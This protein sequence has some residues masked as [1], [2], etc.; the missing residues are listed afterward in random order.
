MIAAIPYFAVPL[1]QFTLPVIGA[2]PLDPWATLVCIGFVVGLEVARAR[3]I[4]QGFDTRDVI[5]GAVFIVLSGFLWGHVLNV[6]MYYPERLATEGVVSL[7][8][9]W[10]GFASFGGFFGAVLGAGLFYRWIRPRDLW[11]YADVIAY[12]FPFGWFFGRLG[13]GVVHDHVGSLTAMPWGMDFDHAW[14]GSGDPAPW[15]NGIRHE[16]GLEE[17]AWMI[18][19]MVLFLWLGR[20]E[21]P[22][23][24]FIGWFTVLYAPMRFFLECFRNT[25]L[26]APDAR[27]FGYTPAQYGSV[28]ILVLGAAMLVSIRQDK[29][30]TGE[31]PT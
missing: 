28:L 7:L 19:V 2:V 14:R 23:G 4:R 5:D 26:A 29:P 15:A 17:A 13:C 9:V 30:E 3:G 20:R 24:F 6:V 11:R 8:K 10:D 21:R 1:E 16:L 18:P 27:Y 25:D 12:G 22:G 31:P